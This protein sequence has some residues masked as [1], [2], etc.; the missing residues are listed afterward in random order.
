[1]VVVEV[2]MDFDASNLPT[3]TNLIPYAAI[4]NL[5]MK[6]SIPIAVEKLIANDQCEH[7]IVEY[8]TSGNTMNPLRLS[9]SVVVFWFMMR[10]VLT[11]V[12]TYIPA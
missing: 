1:M 10:T 4:A 12:G 8:W 11:R 6:G 3:A 7:Y 2:H 5:S 9:L